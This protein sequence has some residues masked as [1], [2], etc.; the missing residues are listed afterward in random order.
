[1]KKLIFIG[2][3]FSL[4]SCVKEIEFEKTKWNE[5]FDGFYEYRENMVNDLMENHLRKGM[6]YSEL[7]ELI[8]I[9]TNYANLESNE[10]AYEIMVDYHWN[11]DPM[12]GKD[13]YFKLD[14]DSTVINFRI[15]HW[16]H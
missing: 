3:C 7:T 2:I 15:E 4:I 14:N 13:L 11:I 8:G 1:M 9:P 6:S 12:E 5:R 16:E 10:I